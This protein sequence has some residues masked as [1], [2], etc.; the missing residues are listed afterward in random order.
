VTLPSRSL[1]ELFAAVSNGS[2]EYAVVPLENSVSGLLQDVL[3]TLVATQGLHIVG[4]V[5]V[6]EEHCLCVQPGTK[7]KDIRSVLSHSH[8]LMQSEAWLA[9]LESD[10]GGH[11]IARQCTFD[12]A[13]ACALVD[14]PTK[15]AISSRRAGEAAG[16]EIAGSK[17]ADL[18]SETRYIVLSKSP[19]SVSNR[20]GLRCSVSFLLRNQE[21]AMFKALSS[22]AFRNLNI[23]KINSLPL[24]GRRDREAGSIEP[25]RWD[26]AFVVDFNASTDQSINEA[27]LSNLREFAVKVRILGQYTRAE[28]ASQLSRNQSLTGLNAALY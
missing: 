4:E 20:L 17:L 22:F 5:L 12:S 9:A 27:A 18:E 10:N 7:K 2:C 14:S 26:Y 21:G 6:Q 3:L 11:T 28:S 8:L 19:A 25:G 13:G 23:T 24:G 16:L 15:A 1:D